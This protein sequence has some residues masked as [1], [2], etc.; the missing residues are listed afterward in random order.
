M[1]VSLNII[2][3]AYLHDLLDQ[4]EALRRAASGLT[5]T[6]SAETIACLLRQADRVVLTGM[7]SSLYA[8]Y[9]LYLRLLDLGILVHLTETAELIHYQRALL[10]AGTVLAVSQSGRSAEIVRLAE[11]LPSSSR[12]L[13]ITNDEESP[14]ARRAN[15]VL[16]LNAGPEV[17]V[18]CKTYLA[19]L[20]VLEWISRSL[21]GESSVG[22]QLTEAAATVERYLC[23]WRKH[24]DFFASQSEGIE[25]LFLVGR[26]PSLAA[27]E[28]GGLI[29]K[30]STRFAAEGMSSAAFRHG[31]VEAAGPGTMVLVFQGEDGAALLSDRLARDIKLAGGRA[32]LVG[33]AGIGSAR[34]AATNGSCPLTIREILPV[35]MLSLALAAKQ[36][37]EAGRFEHA[38]KI[39]SL[40]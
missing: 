3:G 26:G 37:S 33:E 10:T 23:E 1:P 12:L 28:T 18:S 38:T 19:S 21:S 27:A 9:P 17:T 16:P 30:E 5:K 13:A 34:L 32:L 35:Q 4:P 6:S 25:K 39:T 24:V 22:E 31:P 8:L 36:G 40:E 15:L 14:L 29:L 20:L 11:E 2:E 7:G